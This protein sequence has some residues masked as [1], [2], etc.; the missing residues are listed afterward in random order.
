M[1]VV[2]GIIMLSCAVYKYHRDWLPENVKIKILTE[3]ILEFL[4][5]RPLSAQTKNIIKQHQKL[6]W[7]RCLDLKKIKV[8]QTLND[9]KPL[10][11][12]IFLMDQAVL[13]EGN[14][15]ALV[16]GN[17]SLY[18]FVPLHRIDIMDQ[19]IP[20]IKQYYLKEHIDYYFYFSCNNSIVNQKDI[21]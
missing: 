5:D 12:Q 21:I 4:V 9:P 15:V 11:I 17:K 20:E 10:D 6:D 3:V 18:F 13:K 8:E 14:F 2:S 16:K 19:I 7:F 1:F